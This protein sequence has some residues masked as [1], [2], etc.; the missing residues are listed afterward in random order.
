MCVGRQD[1]EA[2]LG[3]LEA[4]EGQGPV[5]ETGQFLVVEEM[6]LPACGHRLD[7]ERIHR[8]RIVAQTER[9]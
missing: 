5:Q 6:V 4:V 1:G 7:G 2:D 9:A 3:V 8:K